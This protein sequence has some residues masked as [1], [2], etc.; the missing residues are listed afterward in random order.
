MLWLALIGYVSS[1]VVA[2]CVFSRIWDWIPQSKS[3][4]DGQCQVCA[5]PQKAEGTMLWTELQEWSLLFCETALIMLCTHTHRHTHTHLGMVSPPI[6][7]CLP[8][9]TTTIRVPGCPVPW[10]PPRPPLSLPPPGSHQ[11]RKHFHFYSPRHMYLD[12]EVNITIWLCTPAFWERE[13]K[14]KTACDL[15]ISPLQPQHRREERGIHAEREIFPTT[16]WLFCWCLHSHTFS[17]L[18]TSETEYI[19]IMYY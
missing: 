4:F 12:N 13:K 2:S 19:Q 5:A 11:W 15:H 9:S 14:V 17:A 3:R 1:Q 8:P 10:R 18:N 16:T 6:Q 7:A